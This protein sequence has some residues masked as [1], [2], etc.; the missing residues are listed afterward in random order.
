MV[1]VTQLLAALRLDHR[2]DGADGVQREVL[3][4]GQADVTR[5]VELGHGL[6]AFL[7]LDGVGG[8][9]LGEQRLQFVHELLGVFFRQLVAVDFQR[10]RLAEVVIQVVAED[11][12]ER[13]LVGQHGVAVLEVDQNLAAL[14]AVTRDGA[15]DFMA[16]VIHGE[17]MRQ[18]HGL[19]FGLVG[20]Q[21]AGERIE[22]GGAFED[23]V[24]HFGG[25][26]HGGHDGVSRLGVRLF[27]QA[28]AEAD[29]LQGASGTCLRGLGVGVCPSDDQ[30]LVW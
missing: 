27:E 23:A 30:R 13:G 1:A 3:L 2:D 25:V 9:I 14:R 4:D 22:L 26:A 28:R 21:R 18:G 7:D 5:G 20:F 10:E 15:G 19:Q 16:S 12:H 24:H 6:D 29:L 11:R 8:A 17:V